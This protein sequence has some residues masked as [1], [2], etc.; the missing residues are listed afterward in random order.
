MAKSHVCLGDK[1]SHFYPMIW[2]TWTSQW[3]SCSTL[4]TYFRSSN[5]RTCSWCQGFPPIIN[6]WYRRLCVLPWLILCLRG[7]L[8]CCVTHCS[9]LLYPDKPWEPYRPPLTATCVTVAWRP[10]TCAW[11]STSRTPWQWPRSWRPTP[12]WTESSSQVTE[13]Y[14]NV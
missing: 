12:G 13:G 9:S 3:S 10:C 6:H 8:V 5:I 1:P 4:V 7:W 14:Q 11:G 2:S